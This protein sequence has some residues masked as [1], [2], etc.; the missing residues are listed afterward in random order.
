M[1][2]VSYKAIRLFGQRCPDAK[3]PL[4]RWYRVTKGA[5]WASFVDV[6]Q[7][8]NTADW[9][10]PYIVFDIGGNRYRLVAEIQFRKRVV[11]IRNIMTHKEYEKGGWKR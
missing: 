11:F 7:S 2:V 10:A 1:H 4:D 5:D 3:T 8:F 9:V 6:K